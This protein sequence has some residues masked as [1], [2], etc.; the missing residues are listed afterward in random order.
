MTKNPAPDETHPTPKVPLLS[1][2]EVGAGRVQVWLMIILVAISPLMAYGSFQFLVAREMPEP[3]HTI[4]AV[5]DIALGIL[6]LV[7][8]PK[9]LRK[10]S[11]APRWEVDEAR[12]RRALWL[13]AI[14]ISCAALSGMAAFTS[15]AAVV[16]VA[17]RRRPNWI[18][19]A[20]F[21]CCFAVG[22]LTGGAILPLPRW[23]VGVAGTLLSAALIFFG[24][25]LGGRRDLVAALRREADAARS[26]RAARASEARQ[27]ERTR[28]A[29]E[30]HDAVSHRLALVALHAGAL[31]YRD[32]LSPEKLRE[33]VGVIRKG[34][35]DAQEELQA[36]LLVLRTD[37]G[38]AHP[39]ATIADLR[40]LTDEV[41]AAGVPIDLTIDLPT[42][43]A[44]P[45]TTSAHLHRIV[46]ESLTNA[47]KH[48]PG[49][50]VTVVV[51]GEANEGVR[52]EIRNPV[53][54]TF[55]RGEG[56]RVGLIGLRERLDLI[57]GTFSAGPEKGQFV[58]RAW[59]PW[60]H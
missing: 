57:G 47:V 48:A 4:F 58:V 7:L 19:V 37:G 56:S 55:H 3:R 42:D 15:M 13:G 35:H 29:R 12:E 16:S 49:Q 11:G 36:T 6:A 32:D 27:E 18:G 52:L 25:Y 53:G 46:Q 23:Q 26:S 50:P 8:L 14:V 33:A 30:M 44:P 22:Y 31:E 20:T 38:D 1:L 17:G 40:A 59:V 43:A 5:L 28:I 2:P 45:E 10:D 39:A 51:D 60:K 9:V 21:G 34:V 24:L 41:A 54:G